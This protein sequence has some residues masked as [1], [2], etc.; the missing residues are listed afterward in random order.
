[1]LT[2]VLPLTSFA[3]PPGLIS[4]KSPFSVTETIDRLQSV[5]ES[6]G[7]TIVARIDHAAGAEKVG[8]EL[9]AEELLIFGNPKLGTPLIASAPTAGIDLPMKALSYADA[10]GQVWLVYNAPVALS[11][12]HGITDQK[13]IIDKMTGAL[14]NFTNAALSE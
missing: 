10:D 5:L 9:A 13:E 6:K 2:V 3:E 12:R 1:M 14:D 8:M 11:D 7:M 4:K